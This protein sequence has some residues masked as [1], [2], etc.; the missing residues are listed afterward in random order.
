[1]SSPRYVEMMAVKGQKRRLAEKKKKKR[2]E[3][4]QEK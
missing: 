1:M 3:K 2:E 4:G